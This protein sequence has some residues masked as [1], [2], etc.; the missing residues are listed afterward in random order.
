MIYMFDTI[1]AISSGLIN[2]PISIIRLS[3]SD[4]FIIVRK[5]FSKEFKEHGKIVLGYILKDNQKIDEVLITPFFGPHSF[6]GEDMVE[7]YAH[8]G[9]V[10]TKRILKLLLTNGARNAN[11]GEFSLRAVLN[12]KM[13]L[14]KA[15]AIHDLIFASTE[16]QADLSIKKFDGQTSELINR[17]K[18]NLLQLIATCEVNI[19]YPEYDDIETLTNDNL[20]PKIKL[21]LD[22]INKIIESSK[23]SRFV[24][25]GL[26]VAIVG[27]P[28]SGKSSLLNALLNEDKA[29]ISPTAG[30]TR[31]VVEGK[32]Q[33]G[34]ILLNLKDTAGIHIT[35]DEIE[36]QGINKAFNEIKHADLILHII[37]GSQNQINQMQNNL[38]IK[39]ITSQVYLQIINKA[40]LIVNKDEN[41]IYISAKNNDLSNL[42]KALNNAFPKINLDN[43]YII[44]N[45]RQ[46]ALID[47]TKIHLEKSLEGL[48]QHHTPDTIIIDL[49]AAWTS[50]ANILG[51]ANNETLLDEMFHTF[52]LGK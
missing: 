5:I 30:T 39:N 12:K 14:I 6:T 36:N 33:I 22:E 49:Q 25:E 42:I 26:R 31:D 7:I 8:G 23:S 18:N 11:R 10:N 34:Q 3:G 29:I 15:E 52:C 44:N 9:I 41:Q 47:E 1:A 19:D 28:N 2:Q 35:T 46:L 40:D 32:L 21:M 27:A 17:L 4:A 51:T 24:F 16:E 43:K 48:S 38:I 45:V 13:D 20:K 37:D 50:L